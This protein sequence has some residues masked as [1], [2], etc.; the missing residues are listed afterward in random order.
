MAGVMKDIQ[1]LLYKAKE[2]GN[3]ELGEDEIFPLAFLAQEKTKEKLFAGAHFFIGYSGITSPEIRN[4]LELFRENVSASVKHEPVTDIYFQITQTGEEK[5]RP[6]IEGMRKKGDDWEEII[7]EL[8]KDLKTDRK[9]I[10]QEAVNAIR[11]KKKTLQANIVKM[12]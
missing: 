5:I 1:I 6:L 10:I 3:N 12:V 8:L 9:K 2:N 7:E 4:A 11:K